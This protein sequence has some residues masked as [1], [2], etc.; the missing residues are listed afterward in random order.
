MMIENPT[1]TEIGEVLKKSKTI[2]VVG[3]SDK[4]E[5]T[6]YMVSKA[7]Q[8]AGY[9]IIPVNP[10]VD[11]VLGEKAV[12]SLK[13]IKEHVDIVNVFRRSEFLMDVAKEFVEI[14]ADVFWA[15]LGVQDED[16]YQ[17]LKEKDYTVIMDRCIKV[18][19]AMT[20]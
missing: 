20:K 18:E 2:A 11:E 10:T 6:S 7:M 17:L 19:H 12:A 5:R 4:P 16:T 8:D 3:L 9:R 1:R 14:D 13:D 15:Q